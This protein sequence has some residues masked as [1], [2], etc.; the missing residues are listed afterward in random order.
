MHVCSHLN[1]IMH[2]WLQALG[3]RERHHKSCSI[4]LCLTPETDMLIEPGVSG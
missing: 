4:F 3:A 1:Y 2:V